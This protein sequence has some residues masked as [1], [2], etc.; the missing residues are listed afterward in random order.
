M[1][2]SSEVVS[3]RRIRRGS[4]VA[5]LSLAAALA[6]MVGSCAPAKPPPAPARPPPHAVVRDAG[7]P[8]DASADRDAD[9]RP[10]DAAS[11]AP[12]PPIEDVASAKLAA[13]CRP[14]PN[15]S[16]PECQ[17]DREKGSVVWRRSILAQDP[18]FECALDAMRMAPIVVY[19]EAFKSARPTLLSE[20]GSLPGLTTFHG[21]AGPGSV[22]P[23]ASSTS[24]RSI[25]LFGDSGSDYGALARIATLE[26]LVLDDDPLKLVPL[27]AM[28]PKE[29]AYSREPST[30]EEIRHLGAL[31]NL[32]GLTL[33]VKARIDLS[34]LGALKRLT[35][36]HLTAD[37][38]LDISV[39]SKLT[40]LKKVTL[41][42]PKVTTLAPLGALPA[43]AELELYMRAVTDVRPL[44][45][46]P[47]LELLDIRNTS[48]ADA[49]PLARTHSKALRSL[50]LG[51][52][53]P[54]PVVAALRRV[55]PDVGIS[56]DFESDR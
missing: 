12:P 39:L 38:P 40:S 45:G 1:R 41:I 34:P 10:V 43:L 35:T 32:T 25:M 22:A 26:E 3:R 21:T 27:A 13:C 4:V 54:R 47:Q 30:S 42:L 52:L 9:A 2:Y 24:L 55:L 19:L 50:L 23:L 53:V 7:P 5:I 46:L 36:L 6:I 51:Y 20:V 18:D 8:M 33:R 31:T 56:H 17:Y 49:M 14:G 16:Y 44:V 29:F 28:S 48:I 37:D 15:K 11:D